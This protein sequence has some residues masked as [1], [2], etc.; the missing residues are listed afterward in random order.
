MK[1]RRT[2]SGTPTKMMLDVA[3]RLAPKK[4]PK[5]R[6]PKIQETRPNACNPSISS[7]VAKLVAF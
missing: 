5:A 4:K 3:V 7:A 1:N 2:S 6:I